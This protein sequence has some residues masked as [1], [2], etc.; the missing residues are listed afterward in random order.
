M[1]WTVK[2]LLPPPHLSLLLL[3]TERGQIYVAKQRYE[4]IGIRSNRILSFEKGEELEVLN[5]AANS[6]WWEAISLRTGN[7]GDVPASYL[8]KKFGGGAGE[9]GE[10]V[11]QMHRHSVGATP[12]P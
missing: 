4:A 12:L 8:V 5:A 10:G 1:V 3:P 2:L 7:K 9:D 6:D 11:D